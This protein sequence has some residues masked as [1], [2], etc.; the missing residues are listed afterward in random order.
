MNCMQSVINILIYIIL[1]FTPL[2]SYA[3]NLIPNPDFSDVTVIYQNGRNVFPNHW[4]SISNPTTHFYHPEKNRT[5]DFFDT[6][7]YIEKSPGMIG[8]CVFGLFSGIFT[9]LKGPLK[10]NEVYVIEIELQYY[11]I[12]FGRTLLEYQNIDPLKSIESDLISLVT[13]FTPAAED[14]TNKSNR[15]CVILDFSPDLTIDSVQWINLSHNYIAG[16]SEK[17]FSI[18][19]DKCESY[20]E[21]LQKCK[22]DTIEYDNENAYFLIRNVSIYPL[23]DDSPG[24]VYFT[25][26]FINDSITQMVKDK[27]RFVLRNINFDFESYSLDDNSKQELKRIAGFLTE[28]PKYNLHIHGHTDTIGTEEFNMTLSEN[29]AQAVFHYLVEQGISSQRLDYEG[30]GESQLLNPNQLIN[31]LGINRRVEFEFITEEE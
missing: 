20:M 9:E 1:T 24:N 17:Y 3:Q 16:G 19:L 4:K 8:I 14:I 15:Q 11:D 22:G 13:Y 7:S 29:R 6:D 30:R 18:G 25:N 12:P 26:S 31:N 2:F 10:Q 28:H 21:V 27:S 23:S 5:G